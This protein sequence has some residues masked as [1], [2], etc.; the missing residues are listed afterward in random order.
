MKHA[1]AS[2]EMQNPLQI[3]KSLVLACQYPVRV[4]SPL[5]SQGREA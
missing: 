4:V 5:G 2:Y 1:K 3:L